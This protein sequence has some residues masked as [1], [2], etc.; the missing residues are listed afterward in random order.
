MICRGAE[1]VR[2]EEQV[3]EQRLDRRAVVA[4]P[5]IARRLARGACSSR[6]SVLLP[7]SGAQPA[8]RASSLPMVA[9]VLHGSEGVA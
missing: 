6:F 9:T 8:R 7:A 2:V 4:D 1:R 5:V 3:D